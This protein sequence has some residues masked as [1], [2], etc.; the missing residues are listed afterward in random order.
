M[1]G[2]F[3]KLGGV[4]QSIGSILAMPFVENKTQSRVHSAVRW[5]FHAL[6]V[7]VILGGLALLNYSL[8]LDRV[9]VT[10]IAEL[11]YLWL[12]AVFLLVY[13]ISWIG[14]WTFRMLSSPSDQ[15]EYADICHE[16]RRIQCRLTQR[17]IDL[18][19]TP[20]FLLLGSPRGGAE[21]FLNAALIENQLPKDRDGQEAPFQV[22]ASSDAVYVCCEGSSLLGE[23]SQLFHRAQEVGETRRRNRSDRRPARN[24]IRFGLAAGDGSGLS[25]GIED[26]P[27][28]SIHMVSPSC[29]E[30]VAV[31]RTSQS[32]EESPQ[33]VPLPR[34]SAAEGENGA[35]S[36][37]AVELSDGCSPSSE[38]R[39]KTARPE[40]QSSVATAS[41]QDAS[42]PS[43]ATAYETLSV[44]ESNIALLDTE[45]AQDVAMKASQRNPTYQPYVEPKLPL[46]QDENE[47]KQTCDRL[48][49]LCKLI[50]EAREP[51]CSLNGVVTLVPYSCL[52]NERTANH[53]GMLIQRDLAVIQQETQLVLPRIAVVCDIQQETGSLELL[54]RFPEQQRDRRLGIKFPYIPEC[55]LN[56]VDRLVSKGIDWLCSHMIPPLVNRL[57]ETERTSGIAEASVTLSNERLYSLMNSLRQRQA[58]LQR[59]IRRGFL[60]DSNQGRFLRGCYLA[61]TGTDSF[62]SQGFSAGIIQQV[63]EMQNDVQWSE[64]ALR[65]DRERRC[66][67][68]WGYTAIAIIGLV[69]ILLLI[70]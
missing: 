1:K 46:L 48:R 37:P 29:E 31:R 38:Q 40:S 25:C 4:F 36:R 67:T 26:A 12:P 34:E 7:V 15:P 17:G 28:S 24:F 32:V 55:D 8:K 57:F 18:L 20:V 14:W 33:P 54:T 2:L 6:C 69:S 11:R 49:Y 3:A 62:S 27:E 21:Q 63:S 10:P 35:V 53:C 22:F 47:I 58:A 16:W 65:D 9:L 23:Q 52:A 41:I 56:A 70:L 68:R 66:W 39:G 45:L 50:A 59:L 60:S 42:S 44:V 43:A 19:T 51:F 13:S 61:A 30:P 5:G 64:D